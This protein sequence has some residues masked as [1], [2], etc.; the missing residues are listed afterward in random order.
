MIKRHRVMGPFFLPVLIL[1][2]AC[3]PKEDSPNAP[4]LEPMTIIEENLNPERAQGSL[5]ETRSLLI[6]NARILTAAENI[7]SPGYLYIEQ[8]LIKAIGEGEPP[9]DLKAD[10]MIDATG[11]AV[12]PGFI[13]THSHMGVYPLPETQSHRDG[14]EATSATRPDVWAEHSFWPQDPSLWRAR[15]GGVTT[16]QALPG[17]ANLVGGRGVTLRLIPHA[18]DIHEMKFPG[19]PQGLK[20]AC[21]ENPKR[22]YGEK[23]GPSTRMGNVAGYRNLFQKALEY[24][25]KWQE[26]RRDL[27]HWQNTKSKKDPPKTPNRDHGLDTMVLALNGELRVHI[28][29]YRADE[30]ALMIDLAHDYGFQIAS[31]HHGLEAYKIAPRLAREGIAT[32]TWTDWW[33][34][35]MEAFDGVPQNLAILSAKGADAILHSDSESDIRFLNQEAAKAIGYARRI[36]IEISDTTA[37]QWL[38]LNP[39]KALKI[40]DRVGTLEVGKDA[41]LVVWSQED[42]FSA[43]ARAELTLIKGETVYDHK[44]PSDG[45]SDFEVGILV[46]AP[47]PPIGSGP[48]PPKDALKEELP[49]LNNFQD[50]FA[51]D[52]AWIETGDLGYYESGRVIVRQGKIEQ[53]GSKSL[54]LPKDIQV[55]Q[56]KGGVVTPG[57][58]ETQSTLGLALVR[59]EK[60]DI[61]YGDRLNP[62]LRAWDSFD[63][64]SLRLPIAREQGITS[65]LIKPGYSF[66][67]GMGFIAELKDEPKVLLLSPKQQWLHVSLPAKED[68]RAHFYQELREAFDE[69]GLIQSDKASLFQRQNPRR[70]GKIAPLTQVLTGEIPLIFEAYRQDD[71]ISAIRLRNEL[72]QKGGNIELILKGASEAWLIADLLREEEVSVLIEPHDQMPKKLD[73]LRVRD[74]LAL[75]LDKAQVPFAFTSEGSYNRRLRQQAGYA[76]RYG[77]DYRKAFASITGAPATILGL[78]NRG[79]LAPGQRADLLLWS[80][81][82]LEPTSLVQG[83]WI[84]GKPQEMSTRQQQLARRYWDGEQKGKLSKR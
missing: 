35:K 62:S 25:R 69:A 71:L 12:T 67:G 48:R 78:K 21:G 31:F 27:A 56:A 46:K 63:S 38:T 11:K 39:A 82:P 3:Q 29:C 20:M 50:T 10:A 66:V 70:Y 64:R 47:L 13:D 84:E 18:I 68:S 30:M 17:S 14:N 52:D 59:Y 32:S 55:L 60:N 8:G 80:G 77:L 53:V 22:V 41:D 54:P 74:D 83:V 51:I 37:L 26:Y 45:H 65:A 16:I 44:N 23:G 61:E 28:H 40:E 33:G 72:N 36:G 19:A 6:K 49:S 76:V 57:L 4:P 42:V 34:F 73:R 24:D 9:Q 58:I 81:D 43:Y 7:L 79:T 15:A 1:F 75:H 5:E 2:T